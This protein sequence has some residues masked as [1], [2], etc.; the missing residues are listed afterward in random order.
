MNKFLFLAPEELSAFYTQT[1]SAPEVNEVE[2]MRK[3]ALSR[4]NGGF[5]IDATYWFA[6]IT[7]KIN[8]LKKLKMKYLDI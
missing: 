7:S 1:M 6:T 3:I 4:P 5:E 8:L 2:K